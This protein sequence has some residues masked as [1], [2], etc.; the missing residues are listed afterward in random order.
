MTI[1][2]SRAKNTRPF[3]LG[4]FIQNSAGL[5]IES[6][7]REAEYRYRLAPSGIQAVLASYPRRHP[8]PLAACT[9]RLCIAAVNAKIHSVV[10]NAGITKSVRGSDATFKLMLRAVRP[11][12]R[13]SSL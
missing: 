5:E 2:A 8:F 4:Y 1:K 7:Y 3:L 9:S 11:I 13:D 10:R 12:E 6:R